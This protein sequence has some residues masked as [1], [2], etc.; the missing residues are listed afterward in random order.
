MPFPPRAQTPRDRDALHRVLL[1]TEKRVYDVTR[2]PV[3]RARIANEPEQKKKKK[4]KKKHR[5]ETVSAR[6]GGSEN[7]TVL[8]YTRVKR[9]LEIEFYALRD[10]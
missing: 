5:R 8:Q 3:R 1:E 4:E 2:A 6:G 10:V 7:E 9:C